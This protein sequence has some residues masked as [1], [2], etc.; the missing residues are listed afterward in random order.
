MWRLR[1]ARDVTPHAGYH[2]LVRMSESFDEFTIVTQNV[3]GL[4]HRSGSREVIELHGSLWAFRCVDGAHAYPLESVMRVA[5]QGGEGEVPPPA[6]VECGSLVRPGVVWFGEPLPP[7]A[8]E[9]SWRAVEQA[10]VVLVVGT[11]ALVYPAADLPRVAQSAG[12]CVV[13]INSEVTPFSQ[14]ADVVVREPAGSALPKLV[15][16]LE[17]RE[18]VS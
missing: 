5:E 8:V 3:D 17:T 4:H 9:R 14:R 18:P 15:D 13:E 7:D 2:A 10:D 1:L 11:S 12:A 16:H 6:C